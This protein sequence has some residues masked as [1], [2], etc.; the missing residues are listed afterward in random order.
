MC[1]M[2]QFDVETNVSAGLQVILN[3]FTGVTDTSMKLNVTI[4]HN[5][6][7]KMTIG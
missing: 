3:N 5:M 6:G 7:M 2:L 4:Q 1:K